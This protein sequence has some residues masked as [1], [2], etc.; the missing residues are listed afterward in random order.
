MKK[1]IFI[2]L[3]IILT[4]IAGYRITLFVIKKVSGSKVQ[5]SEVR[6]IPVRATSAQKQDLVEK[7]KLTGDIKGI[8]VVNVF[9]QVGGKIAKILVKEGDRVYKGQTLM[10]INRDI[11]GMQYLPAIVDSPITGYIGTMSVDRGM[12]VTQTMPLCQVVNMSSVEAIV[13]IIEE[14]INRVKMGMKAEVKVDA[15][16][17]KT[18]T[19]SIYKKSA[20]IDPASRT[21]EVHIALA[22]KNNMLKHGMFATIEVITDTRKER[23]VIPVDAILE[24]KDGS[25]Y[26]YT[27]NSK[28]AIKKKITTGLKVD[29]RIEVTSGLKEGELVA[30]LGK[31]NIKQGNP[32]LVYL[33][34]QEQPMDNKDTSK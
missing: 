30:T 1:K 3:V 5:N 25:Q 14:Y 4:L 29:Q 7:L 8:E 28:K 2:T 20:T 10:T 11:V 16:P 12:T 32:V 23:L 21:Q 13:Y 18:F 24:E 34:D 26:V 31:E 22:N 15:Y 27:V 33:D 9:P 6:A 19:G 17:G